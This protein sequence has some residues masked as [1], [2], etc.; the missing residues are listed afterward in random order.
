MGNAQLEHAQVLI[1]RALDHGINFINI[2]DIYSAGALEAIVGQSLRN[3]GAH[4]EDVV[5]ANKVCGPMGSGPNDAANSRVHLLDR[6]K[7]SL[8][9]LQPLPTP[10][11]VNRRGIMTPDRHPILTPLCLCLRRGRLGGEAVEGVARRRLA[12]KPIATYLERSDGF[13]VLEAP[14]LIA[15]FDDVAMVG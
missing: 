8:K 13:A 10:Q 7:A 2:A 12:P 15:G 4:R 6:F 9:R 1:Y 11:H 3:L 14:A 5:I